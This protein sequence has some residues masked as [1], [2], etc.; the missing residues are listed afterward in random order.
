[1][2]INSEP[3]WQKFKLFTGYKKAIIRKYLKIKL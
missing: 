3:N 1:L 2:G